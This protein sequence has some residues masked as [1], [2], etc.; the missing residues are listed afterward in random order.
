MA[1]NVSY[2][3]LPTFNG[4]AIGHTATQRIYQVNSAQD[5]WLTTPSITLGPGIYIV[6][7]NCTC[8]NSPNTYMYILSSQVDNLNYP[9]GIWFDTNSASEPNTG[10]LAKGQPF[11]TYTTYQPGLIT[12]VGFPNT[13]WYPIA[14]QIS[15]GPGG[16]TNS[17][18]CCVALQVNNSTV[19]IV[20]TFFNQANGS[21]GNGTLTATRIS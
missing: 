7:G 16:A 1:Y 10:K 15:Y 9:N 8:S 20:L 4:N 18:S 11:N 5:K 17:A 21:I 12:V 19:Q 3:T 13:D 6:T 14:N 2:T